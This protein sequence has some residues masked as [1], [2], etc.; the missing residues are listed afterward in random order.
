MHNLRLSDGLSFFGHD[1][2]GQR[3]TSFHGGDQLTAPEELHRLTLRALVVAR[4][5]GQN[6]GRCEIRVPS[7]EAV[8]TL[9]I[10]SNHRASPPAI[11]IR[12]GHWS[13]AQEPGSFAGILLLGHVAG[14]KLHFHDGIS[15]RLAL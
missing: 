2:A 4:T 1:P 7:T 12:P 8:D 14:T 11:S 15:Y 5:R 10:G 9:G 13:W 3:H 6:F